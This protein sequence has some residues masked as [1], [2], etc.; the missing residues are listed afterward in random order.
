M[1]MNGTFCST[2]RD[3]LRRTGSCARFAYYYYGYFTAGAETV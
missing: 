2:H 3:A 1:T